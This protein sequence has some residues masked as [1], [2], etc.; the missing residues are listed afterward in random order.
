M[1]K[2]GFMRRWELDAMMMTPRQLHRGQTKTLFWMFFS[3]LGAF[4]CALYIQHYAW[5]P[6]FGA[7]SMATVMLSNFVRFIVLDNEMERRNR[8]SHVQADARRP[9]R[10]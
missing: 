4:T 5:W 7:S 2:P 10:W 1:T 9:D 6:V 3:A 8:V